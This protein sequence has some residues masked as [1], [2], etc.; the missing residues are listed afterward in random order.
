MFFSEEEFDHLN[1]I[2]LSE[3]Y[4]EYNKSIEI[5]SQENI[6]QLSIESFFTSLFK[7]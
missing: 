3:V 6:R 1:K 4:I 7:K 2:E 5:F